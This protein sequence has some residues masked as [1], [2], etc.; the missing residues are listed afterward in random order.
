MLYRR[1]DDEI[2]FQ[3]HHHPEYELTLTLNS[4]GERFIG[5]HIGAYDDGDLVLVGPNLPHT[6]RSS[7]K[8]DDRRPHVALVMWFLPAWAEALSASFVELAGIRAM[9]GRAAAG[10]AFSPGVSDGV[11]PLVEKL[12]VASK[13]ERL[14]L[15]F[16]VLNAVSKDERAVP[17]ASRALVPSPDPDRRRIDRVLDHIHMNYAE[18]WSIEA[19]ADVAALSPS[20][21]HRLFRR[22][23]GM[24]VSEYVIRMRIGE[25]CA[26]LSATERPIAYIADAVGYRT[27]ANFNRQFLTQKQVTPRAYRQRFA[28][29]RPAV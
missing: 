20:G 24:A 12:F 29:G 27:L 6:W 3:W 25:A 17:L 2:P 7:T 14:L 22:H 19:L 11:R 4:R 15:L 26:M 23:M 8:L 28:S 10:L 21:L 5:D 18:R 9:L 1:L 16:Q 13:D